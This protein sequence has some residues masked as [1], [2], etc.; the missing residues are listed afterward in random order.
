MAGL[1]SIL[2]AEVRTRWRALLVLA[3]L[4]AFVGAFVL[5][6]IAG[7]RRT[8]TALDRFQ[9]ATNALDAAVQTDDAARGRELLEA[10]RAMPEVAAADGYAI[11]PVDGGVDLDLGILVPPGD[12]LTRTIDRPRVLAGRL[13]DPTSATEVVIS[14]AFRDAARV[15]VGDRLSLP[16]FTPEDL[17]QAFSGAGEFPGLRGPAI[18]VEVVGI[19]RV[20]EDAHGSELGGGAAMTGTR[21]MYERYAGSAGYLEGMVGVDLRDPADIDVL[22]ARMRAVAGEE[23]ELFV[24][25][26][27]ARY[28]ESGRD[29]LRVVAYA[30]YAFAALATIAALVVVGQ[31]AGRERLRSRTRIPM[32]RALGASRS[33]CL[34]ALV[35]PQT[36]AAGVGALLAIAGA[37]AVSPLFPFG[38]ARRSEPDPGFDV[39]AIVL[40][41]GGVGFVA[42]A[43]VSALVLERTR[44]FS[45]TRGTRHERRWP[46]KFSPPVDLGLGLATARG[47]GVGAT[48]AMATAIA[49]VVGA[50]L[51]AASLHAVISTPARWGWNI[52]SAPEVGVEEQDRDVL[53]AALRD[54]PDVVDVGTV[55]SMYV[56]VEGEQ[57]PGWALDS[58]A[59]RPAATLLSGREPLPGEVVLGERTL[60][61]T[62]REVGEVVEFRDRA[63]AVHELRV[64]GTASFPLIDAQH[65]ADGAW[66]AP[67]T[68]E[69][70]GVTDGD[71]GVVLTYRDGVDATQ[72]E[73]RLMREYEGLDF[74]IY[75]HARVPGQL[76][77]LDR[78]D[79]VAPALGGFFAVIG[80]AG[81]AHALGS[82]VR[83]RR[84]EYAVVRALG[85]R[86]R[87]LRRSVRWQSYASVFTGAVIGVPGGLLIGR[88]IWFAVVDGLGVDDHVSWPSGVLLL[89]V[90]SAFVAAVMT[91]WWP[92]RRAALASSTQ[93]REE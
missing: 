19:V 28:A 6:T 22:E 32:W 13:P 74:S 44:A 63:G 20:P 89:L 92:A 80:L 51:F 65:P 43:I 66:L 15:D 31:A 12:L 45:R 48:T 76:R 7:G 18:D 69:D 72:V 5:A 52:S 1:L 58:P 54:D 4:T 77:N 23:T 73:T 62:A 86:P 57:V 91:S 79:A 27:D 30:L 40:L 35:V 2:R 82:S 75:S 3:L 11:M 81:L 61:H 38:F 84:A 41:I 37:L 39:D 64:V 47:Y 42:V 8:A 21:A 83:R 88:L 67:L 68:L 70:L 14:E 53:F 59:H 87:D 50:A 36:L 46:A 93:L 24:D 26:A 9:D 71:G 56:D 17:E 85:F 25:G 78:I 55:R 34:A 29:A 90:P 16:S 60:R 49:G 33:Q 10:A